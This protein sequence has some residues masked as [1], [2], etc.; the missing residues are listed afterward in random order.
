MWRIVL[1]KY[2]KLI[3]GKKLLNV[4]EV[5]VRFLIVIFVFEE[6]KVLSYKFIISYFKFLYVI[7]RDY[8][9]SVWIC[10]CLLLKC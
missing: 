5:F 3:E 10:C 6:L 4:Y 8:F 9:R 1:L 2:L 7:M